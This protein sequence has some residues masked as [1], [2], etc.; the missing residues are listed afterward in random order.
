MQQH[1]DSP[2]PAPVKKPMTPEE[3]ERSESYHR[4]IKA[5][6]L[7]DDEEEA[8]EDMDAFRYRMARRI[9]MFLNQWE[10]CPEPLCKRNRGCMAPSGDCI[11]IKSEPMT[12]EEWDKARYEIREA[13]DEK[14]AELGLEDE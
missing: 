11:N 4:R 14:L 6:G 9:V 5:A 12:D 7:S 13:L 3:Q 8:P 2:K 1:D 10:G